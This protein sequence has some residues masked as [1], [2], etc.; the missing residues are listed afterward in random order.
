MPKTTETARPVVVGAPSRRDLAERMDTALGKSVQRVDGV[1]K[2]TGQALYN[3]DISVPNMLYGT[4]W[5]EDATEGHVLE[6]LRP[7]DARS[8]VKPTCGMPD[9]LAQ[10]SSG[11]SPSS[12]ATCSS[13]ASKGSARTRSWASARSAIM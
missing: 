9:R 13:I 2:V 1:A 7:P 5:K 12:T 8:R 10:G 6:A 11:S 3:T 4:A